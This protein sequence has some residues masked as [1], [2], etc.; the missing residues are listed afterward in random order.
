[1]LRSALDRWTTD[2]IAEKL[3]GSDTTT[4]S[5]ALMY[6]RIAGVIDPVISTPS[7]DADGG[8]SPQTQVVQNTYELRESLGEASPGMRIR[9]YS[10]VVAP[11][12]S[13]ERM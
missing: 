11:L 9:E 7:S 10:V 4:I 2:E 6:W 13:D 12:S 3:K 8:S 1:L 5:I